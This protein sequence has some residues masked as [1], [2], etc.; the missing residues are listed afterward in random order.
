MPG[1]D[2][3]CCILVFCQRVLHLAPAI[4]VPIYLAVVWHAFLPPLFSS[5]VN[6]LYVNWWLQVFPQVPYVWSFGKLAVKPILLSCRF[7]VHCFAFLC[8]R[9]CMFCVVAAHPLRCCCHFTRCKVIQPETSISLFGFIY[10]WHLL[11]SSQ[12]S[13]KG[14]YLRSSVWR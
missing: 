11:C 8:A 1:C 4:Q 3:K 5:I 2:L 12:I 13:V 6:M 14:N 9:A 7:V 10:L